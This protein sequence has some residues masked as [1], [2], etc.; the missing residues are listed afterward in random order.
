MLDHLHNYAVLVNTAQIVYF[1]QCCFQFFFE[2]GTST[3]SYNGK[4]YA[5]QAAARS[6]GLLPLSGQGFVV[7]QATVATANFGT[8]LYGGPF[9]DGLSMEIVSVPEPSTW[10]MGLLAAGVALARRRRLAGLLTQLRRS[11]PL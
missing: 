11:I 8:Q 5:T 7:R 6:Q 4:N 1:L 2:S 10:V 3:V 9:T